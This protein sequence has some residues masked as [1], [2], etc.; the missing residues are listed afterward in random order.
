[1]PGLNIRAMANTAI[2]AVNPD[3][4][5]MILRST[6]STTDASGHRTGTYTPVYARAQVQATSYNDRIM[7]DS[8]NIQ[9]VS[10]IVYLEA[11]VV[12]IIRID[13]AGGDQIVFPPGLMPEDTPNPVTGK[14]PVWLV[15]HVLEVY[16][17]GWRK[18]SCTLQDSFSP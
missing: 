6:G 2:Q 17:S 14:A 12:G 7:L 15:T 10:R 3:V 13:K 5:V 9:G 18:V 4:T 16:S 8:L 1:M 11:A